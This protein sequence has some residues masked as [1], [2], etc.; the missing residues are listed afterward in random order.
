MYKIFLLGKEACL[1]A[2]RPARPFRRGVLD[3]VEGG[4]FSIT[5]RR[6]FISKWSRGGFYITG[7]IFK[8]VPYLS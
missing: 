6:W 5:G 7:C 8:T 1:T 4:G 2:V 3:E